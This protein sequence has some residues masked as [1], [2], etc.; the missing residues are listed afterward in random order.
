MEIISEKEK[1]EKKRE[2]ERFLF[3]SSSLLSFTLSF[4][5]SLSSSPAPLSLATEISIAR[6]DFFFDAGPHQWNL[7]L[8]RGGAEPAAPPRERAPK[9]G[10]TKN[11]T[12]SN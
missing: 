7:S 9:R 5:S 6:R 4:S 2:E 8:N 10:R 11:Y 1:E 12:L 3:L